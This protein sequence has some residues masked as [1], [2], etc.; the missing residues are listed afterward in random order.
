MLVKFIQSSLPAICKICSLHSTRV[1]AK[2]KTI[3]ASHPSC[4]LTI[5]CDAAT[6]AFVPLICEITK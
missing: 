4:C 2:P 3:Y 1:K 6:E 5:V